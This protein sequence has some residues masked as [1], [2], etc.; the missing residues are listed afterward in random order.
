M[1][2]DTQV[3]ETMYTLLHNLNN[4]SHPLKFEHL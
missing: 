3:H 4:C 1:Q 2:S